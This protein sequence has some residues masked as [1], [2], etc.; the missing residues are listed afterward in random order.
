MSETTKEFQLADVLGVTTGKLLGEM[1]GL[2]E[3]LNWLTNDELF[4]HQLPRARD[5]CLPWLLHWFPELAKVRVGRLDDMLDGVTGSSREGVC[6][7]WL[8]Y[9]QE[10][11]KLRSTYAI[12]PYSEGRSRS[13]PP[14]R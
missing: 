1:G 5:E 11:L 8:L 4:T 3:I 9:E 6:F 13:N 2:Y 14:V 10:R 12:P 7:G